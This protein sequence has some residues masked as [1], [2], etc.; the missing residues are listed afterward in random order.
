MPAATVQL[1]YR[2]SHKVGAELVS[3]PKIGATGYTGSRGAG[4]VLK[5][6]ADKA[7][8]PIYLE[9]SSINPVVILPGVLAERGAELADLVPGELV[10]IGRVLIGHALGPVV[11]HGVGAESGRR[12][13]VGFAVGRRNDR[14]AGRRPF[15]AGGASDIVQ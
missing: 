11:R 3:H 6:A 14:V 2:T 8:K 7:G 15:E 13:M 10:E 12:S 9:L 5:E 1:I 4:L